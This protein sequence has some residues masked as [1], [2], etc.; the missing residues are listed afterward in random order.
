[1]LLEAIPRALE[2]ALSIDTVRSSW[3]LSGLLP[4]SQSERGVVSNKENVLKRLPI[5]TPLQPRNRC[6]PCISGRI[7]TSDEMIGEIWE[8]EVTRKG[9]QTKQRQSDDDILLYIN[10]ELQEIFGIINQKEESLKHLFAG[11]SRI[12]E[13]EII[14]ETKHV[15]QLIHDLRTKKEGDN[16]Q[17]MKQTVSTAKSDDSKE[18]STVD[19]LKVIIAGKEY[20]LA[21]TLIAVRK[22][23]DVDFNSYIEHMKRDV[24]QQHFSPVGLRG[25][26]KPRPKPRRSMR[27]KLVITD[28]SSS[29]ETD[30]TSREEIPQKHSPESLT[31]HKRK[32]IIA[33]SRFDE[34]TYFDESE[35]EILLDGL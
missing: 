24:Q 16:S 1:M 15:K 25:S 22:M 28:V 11:L 21:E 13:D 35:M 33:N 8:W 7:I 20:S 9:K 5:G 12:A 10:S 17:S 34:Q 30:S 29:E 18:H 3:E 26:A 23:N 32:R 14:T 6:S 2:K 31:T 27:R 4:L 19:D